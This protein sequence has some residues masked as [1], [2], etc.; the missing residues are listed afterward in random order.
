MTELRRVRSWELVLSNTREKNRQFHLLL[1]VV[2]FV[3]VMEKLDCS[4]SGDMAC[5]ISLLPR[6][7]KNNKLGVRTVGGVS[8][9]Q[10]NIFVRFR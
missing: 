5:G 10:Q 2:N 7:N 1:L 6:G 8:S 4:L 3:F 9:V